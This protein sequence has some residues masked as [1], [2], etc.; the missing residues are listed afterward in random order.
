VE[1]NPGYKH[2]EVGVIPVDWNIKPLGEVVTFLDGKRRPVKDTDRA[3]MR[4]S[5]PYYGASGIV[6]YVNDYLFDDE[7]ILLGEDGENILSRNCRLAF[8]ISGKVWV[9]NHAH[10]LKPNSEVSIG[11]LADYLE[12]LNYERY[13]SGTAQPKL[14]KLTC[15]NIPIV[16]PPSRAEQ[17]AIAAAL[18]DADVLIESLEQLVAKKHHVK[19]GAMQ[20][21]L[22]GKNRLPGFTGDWKKRQLGEV[23]AGCSSG[24]TPYRGR[25]EYYNGTVKWITSG[26]LNYNWISDTLEHISEEAAD[27]TNL[28]V[29]PVGTFLMAITGLEAAGTRGACGIVG[30]PATT[31][32]SCMAIYPSAELKTEYL[33]HYYVLRG[34]ELAL[35]YCQGTKQQSYTAKLIKILPIDLPPSVEEQIAIAAVISDMDAEISALE[36]KLAKAC[37]LKQGMM[38]ELLTGKV[39]LV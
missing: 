16:L 11:F 37:Q 27:K 13:N 26:E 1:L 20:E 22:T 19:Q 32:Q 39:R 2:T 12:S 28:K 10:V 17:E 35:R 7:L 4:G 9:N 14:N 34:N 29:H 6:D 33:Y 36:A 38:Q 8:R 31:N 3:K 21:L 24:A 5:Y 25:T 23:I 15:S 18:S 30:S